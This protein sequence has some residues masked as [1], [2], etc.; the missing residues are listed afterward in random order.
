MIALLRRIDT[1]WYEAHI[2]SQ[3][4]IVPVNYLNVVRQPLDVM[5]TSNG[6]TLIS[7]TRK[8]NG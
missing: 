4:G 5:T 7:D 6:G 2:G 3:R 8:A 1:N